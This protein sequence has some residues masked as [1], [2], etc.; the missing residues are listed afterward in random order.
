MALLSTKG[1]APGVYIQEITIPGPLS[2]A[3]TSNLAIVGPAKSG[4]LNRPTLLTNVDQFWKIFA[5]YI[6]DPYRVYA[7]HA[8][9]GFFAEGGTECY[10][11]R[12]GN[13]AAAGLNL[14]DRAGTPQT[15]LVVTALQEGNPATATTVQVSDASLATTTVQKAEATMAAV[16]ATVSTTD[17][18]KKS[19]TV[20]VAA[21]LANFSPGDTVHIDDGAHH[22]DPVIASI[23]GATVNFVA[24]MTNT[25]TSGTMAYS[26]PSKKSVNVTAAAAL[27]NFAPGDSVHLDDGTH[28]DDTVIASIKGVR[29]YFQSAIS[30][31]YISGTVRIADLA[32][33][34]TQLRVASAAKLEPGSVV[35]LSVSGVVKEWAVI[36]LVNPVSKVI[37]LTNPLT[38]AYNMATAAPAVTVTSAEFTLQIISPNAG[39]ETFTALS[40]DSRHSHYF[41]TVVK[42]KAVTVTLPDPPSTTPAPKNIPKVIGPAPLAGGA[43]D[44]LNTLGT[45]FYHAGIDTL[46]KISDVNL[47]CV[48]DAVG[49]HFTAADTQDVQAYMIQHCQRMQDRFAILDSREMLPTET[50]FDTVTNQRASLNSDGGFAGLYFPWIGIS[51]PLGSGKIFVPPSGHTAGVF[52]NTDNTIGVYKAPANEAIT[53]ALA[54]EVPVTDDEQ[55]PLNELGINVIRSFKNEGIKIWGA[56]TIAP[57][58]VTA[59]RFVNVRRLLL[60][61][62]KT[63]QQGTR[64][65]VFE[66]N[67]LTLWQQ[68]KRMVNDFLTDQWRGGALFGDTP[69]RAFRVRV[70]EI[71]NPPDVRALG[72]LVVE[73]TVVPTTPAEFI[74][75]QVVQDITGSTLQEKSA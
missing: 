68:I 66:P 61:I 56:R 6:E 72:I 24:A 44:D 22:D 65:A 32:A 34:A 47:L 5:D 37:G 49:S 53:S 21:D 59:W 69:D 9:N 4:P 20:T 41:D 13:G 54:V 57:Q 27:A 62:E 11:V 71:L 30:F 28:T 50:T 48:P 75:F 29:V 74:I 43:S 3:S 2:P 46:K 25:Y 52:A 12:I 40:M 55:G 7:A 8:V 33:G 1:K 58:D 60:F 36:R 14:A 16:S 64:F 73:V 10:F 15:T 19:I 35:S 38:F 70:D 42:S 23:N 26:D 18:G 17:P 51:N 63:I 39:T 31:P 67:N 45:N